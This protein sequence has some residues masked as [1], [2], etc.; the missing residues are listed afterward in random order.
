MAWTD[1]LKKLF[2]REDI[3]PDD[4]ESTSGSPLASQYF[5]KL[6]LASDR[7][8][9]YKDYSD[10][11]QDAVISAALDIYSEEATIYDRVE[12]STIWVESNN[13]DVEKEIYRLLDLLDVEDFIFGIARYLST[14][15]DN[16]LRPLYGKDDKGIVGMEFV[17]AESVERKVDKYSY[18]IV[19]GFS[20]FKSNKFYNNL[21]YKFLPFLLVSSIVTY[22]L[23]KS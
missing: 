14:Y 16:F 9:K 20:L 8:K 6:Q 17:D 11:S 19:I 12:N 7:V 22:F 13:A 21:Y 15:G 23:L 4:I 10:M 5:E 1:S 3:Q 18:L 2:G